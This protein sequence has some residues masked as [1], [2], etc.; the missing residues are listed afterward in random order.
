MSAC[1]KWVDVFCIS[2]CDFF[3]VV[4]I[5]CM[6]FYVVCDSDIKKI[7]FFFSSVKF[8][9][10]WGLLICRRK[11]NTLCLQLYCKSIDRLTKPHIHSCSLTHQ[12]CY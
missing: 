2:D 9:F 7:V 5:D 10:G 3:V 12:L 6:F 8:I 11:K 4:H 1:V